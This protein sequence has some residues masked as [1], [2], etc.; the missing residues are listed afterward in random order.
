MPDSSLQL[1]I[2]PAEV[3]RRLDAGERLHLIDVRQ[4]EEHRIANLAGSE[5][6][7]MSTVPAA[8]QELEAKAD[9]GELIV[10]CHHG[11]R[12]LNVVNWLREQ[13]VTSCRSMS[14][15]IDQW[16]T[17]IDPSVPRY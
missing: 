16:S 5:L 1:E 9:D 6:V 8:F 2:A 17:D 13:G 15:G 3:K 12:S 10:F 4:P 7:P 11:I 14:G